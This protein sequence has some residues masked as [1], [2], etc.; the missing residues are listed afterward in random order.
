MFWNEFTGDCTS[1]F[2]EA[3]WTFPF[4]GGVSGTV[5]VVAFIVLSV[6]PFLC[7]HARAPMVRT[8]RKR[9]LA[10]R[11]VTEINRNGERCWG[12]LSV[13]LPQKYPSRRRTIIPENS[14]NS[15]A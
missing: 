5:S 2:A 3:V 14:F 6:V 8:M 7:F 9:A 10:E 13:R 12:G 15:E 1:A 11:Y 4:L